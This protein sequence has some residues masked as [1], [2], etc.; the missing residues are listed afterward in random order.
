MT[1]DDV[2]A[3]GKARAFRA[4][5]GCSDAVLASCEVTFVLATFVEALA[6][7]EIDE[8]RAV[9]V[10]VAAWLRRAGEAMACDEESQALL[11]H[12]EAFDPNVEGVRH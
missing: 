7:G 8:P 12:V 4:S 6:D 10:D 2:I 1:A 9:A 11:E 5:P 3:E